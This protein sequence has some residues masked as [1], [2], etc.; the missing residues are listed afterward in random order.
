MVYLLTRK[1]DVKSAN[2]DDEVDLYS[3]FTLIETFANW[4]T[5][6]NYCIHYTINIS[7]VRIFI[8]QTW[9]N[10]FK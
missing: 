6:S 9:V 10:S 4:F 2:N 3:T 8:N 7:N 1:I 5:V